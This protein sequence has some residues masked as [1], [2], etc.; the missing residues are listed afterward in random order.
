VERLDNGSGVGGRESG[1]LE[2]AAFQGFPFGMLIVDRDGG[3]VSSNV[4]ARRLIEAKGLREAE[5]TCCALLGCRTPETV[6][7]E[8]CLTEL[9]LA[10]GA[11][12]PEIRVDVSTGDGAIRALWV[13]IAPL[14]ENSHFVMQLRPGPARDRRRRTDPHW[15]TGPSL[16][17]RTLGRLLVE[18]AQGPLEGS[19]LDQR[20]GQLLRYL[21]TE[22]NRFVQAD[23]IGESLWQNADFAIA[24]SV[25]YYVHALRRKIEPQRGPREPSSFILSRSGGYR[26]N[27][28]LITVD[29]DEFERDI[30]AG[31]AV[32]ESD[33]E[34]AVKDLECGL[35]LYGGDFLTDLPYAEWA[36]AERNR[37]HNLACV[38]LRRLTDIHLSNRA[39]SSAVQSLER[40]ATMT[41]YDE[42]VHRQLMEL[43]IAE[44]RRS[45]AIRRYNALRARIRRTFGHDLDFT[46][47]DLT[48]GA[49]NGEA[50]ARPAE[51]LAAPLAVGKPQADMRA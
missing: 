2:R 28:E 44:G 33:P 31:L 48:T 15:M 47:A 10:R 50:E 14:P 36:M 13:A 5:A 26:L 17:I 49:T 29:A 11:P 21:L 23:E 45:D 35:A 46:P 32:V 41:P 6:L 51:H 3:I 9:A 25:R 22:R 1:A 38:G 8:V 37:L 19:W 12:L 16:R 4:A 42:G 18:S 39:I 30:S 40:L 27:L 24:S 7:A 43:E 20:T 34:A